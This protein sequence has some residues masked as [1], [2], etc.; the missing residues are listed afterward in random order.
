M[1]AINPVIPT[2][3]VFRDE[4]IVLCYALRVLPKTTKLML[5]SG[6]SLRTD[7]I[8]KDVVDLL[9]M[10]TISLLDMVVAVCMVATTT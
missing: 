4:F 6:A 8:V 9:V 7:S 10:L 5:K 1:F 3:G 2:S